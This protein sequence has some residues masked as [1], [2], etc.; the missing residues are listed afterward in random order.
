MPA[1]RAVQVTSNDAAKE[2]GV[3]IFRNMRVPESS[4]IYRISSTENDYGEAEEDLSWWQASNGT[5]LRKQKVLVQAKRYGSSIY[6]II[7][8][9][10]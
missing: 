6:A 7:V 3:S 10:D 5:R 1:L 9:H 8:P 4:V 2:F